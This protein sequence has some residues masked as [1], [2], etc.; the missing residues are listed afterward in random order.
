[1]RQ[2]RSTKWR[3]LR[4]RHWIVVSSTRR[5]SAPSQTTGCSPGRRQDRV[6]R[7]SRFPRLLCLLFLWECPLHCCNC[8]RPLFRP[9]ALCNRP[10]SVFNYPPFQPFTHVRPRN[11]TGRVSSDISDSLLRLKVWKM[12]YS[13]RYDGRHALLS[14]A[15]TCTEYSTTIYRRYLN[16]QVFVSEVQ[17][18]RPW[19]ANRI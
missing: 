19:L 3:Q 5:R 8:R 14:F 10:F 11:S 9:L 12:Q 4:G 16:I 2:G 6:H 1:M 17:T 7:A 15:P 18:A 13:R